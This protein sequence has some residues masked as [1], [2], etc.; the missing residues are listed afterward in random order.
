MR[1][2]ACVAACVGVAT[3]VAGLRR[4]RPYLPFVRLR[5]RL[6]LLLCACASALVRVCVRVGE[7]ERGRVRM[8]M[9]APQVRT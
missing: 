7:R 4:R 5:L 1:V 2:R 8:K 6:R 9:R 3:P